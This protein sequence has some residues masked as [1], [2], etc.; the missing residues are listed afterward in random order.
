MKIDYKKVGDVF[1]PSDYNAITYLIQKYKYTENIPLQLGVTYKGIYANYTFNDPNHILN[2]SKDG[3]EIRKVRVNKADAY[4]YV[5]IEHKYFTSDFYCMLDVYTPN[6]IIQEIEPSSENTEMIDVN[7]NKKEFIDIL[8]AESDIDNIDSP[9]ITPIQVNPEIVTDKINI[10]FD[11]PNFREQAFISERINETTSRIYIIPNQFNYKVGDWI[12]NTVTIGL[13]FDDELNYTDGTVTNTNEIIC[14]TFEELKQAIDTTPLNGSVHIRLKG[15]T[16]NFTKEIFIEN[17]SVYIRGG[18]LDINLGNMPFTVLNANSNCRHF[19]VQNSSK[20]IVENCKFVNGNAYGD[21]SSGT[22]R[23]GGSIYVMNKYVYVQDHYRLNRANVQF[24]YCWF[25][26]NK[27]K[28]GGAIFNSRGKLE[29]INCHFNGNKA[30][31]EFTD[32]D[33]SSTEPEY[34]Q[35][36]WGGAIRSESTQGYFFGENSDRI[37]LEPSSTTREYSINKITLGFKKQQNT[38]ILEKTFTKD[39]CFLV[40]DTQHII[41]PIETIQLSDIVDEKVKYYDITFQTSKPVPYNNQIS[42]VYKNTKN[43]ADTLNNLP[44]NILRHKIATDNK[45]ELYIWNNIETVFKISTLAITRDTTAKTVRLEPRFS[46]YNNLAIFCDVTFN[47]LNFYLRNVTT[48]ELIS[49]TEITR[50]DVSKK[51]IDLTKYYLTLPE[52][53][54]TVGNIYQFEFMGSTATDTDKQ[55]YGRQDFIPA[56]DGKAYKVSQ[57][58]KWVSFKNGDKTDY[59]MELIR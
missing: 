59:K 53:K 7:V 2:E 5:D 47:K 27:A 33:T 23:K 32:E 29:C 13:V 56:H 40:N 52:T 28:Y 16:Y 55:T 36:N 44:S 3:F 9:D 35:W 58:F 42:F 17:K 6:H 19:V 26:K 30:I 49:F 45:T 12:S 21:G 31:N 10:H 22:H 43:S 46:F 38:H 39:N 34:R 41:Y 54:L 14:N 20:L 8:D 48:K 15:K 50:G 24:K 1:E 25:T 57:R 51:L 18:N 4:F 11:H 37:I